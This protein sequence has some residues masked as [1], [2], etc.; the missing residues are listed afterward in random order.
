M[1]AYQLLDLRLKEI[2]Q[3]L[4]ESRKAAKVEQRQAELTPKVAKGLEKIQGQV[5]TPK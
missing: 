3:P 2:A 1:K 5:N 4:I